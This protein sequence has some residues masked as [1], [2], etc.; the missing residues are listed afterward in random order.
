MLCLERSVD[1]ILASSLALGSVMI[2]KS[3]VE[4][5]LASATSGCPSVGDHFPLRFI[6]TKMTF[7]RSKYH[8]ILV[9]APCINGLYEWL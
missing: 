9:I 8:N 4:V 5:A 1:V 6:F 3:V 2:G 7:R